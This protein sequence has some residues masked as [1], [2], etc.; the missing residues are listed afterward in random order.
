M[1]RVG[2]VIVVLVC[3]GAAYQGWLNSQIP[4]DVDAKAAEVACEELRV[5]DGAEPRWASI[6]AGPFLRT[7]RIDE[8]R[9]A[10]TLECRWAS[11]M[12]GAVTCTAQR[13]RV[14]GEVSETPTRRPHELHRG[15]RE[16]H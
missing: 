5:C 10:V 15:N 11:L 4:H 3:G 16:S 1:R 12:V 13:E 14:R 6:D 8:G 7:Y 2:T 9:G